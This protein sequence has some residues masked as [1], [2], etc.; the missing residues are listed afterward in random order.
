VGGVL[1]VV[2]AILGVI[3]FTAPAW[4]SGTA[5]SKFSDI[6]KILTA[7]ETK[8]Y[9]TTISRYYFGWLGWVLLAAAVATAILAVLPGIGSVFRIIAPIVAVAGLV[10]TFI[11]IKFFNDKAATVSSQ[12]S[13]YSTYLKHARLGFWLTVGAFV[14]LAIGGALGPRRTAPRAY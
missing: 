8:T 14:L 13:S 2:G 5:N 3:A 6:H 10:I 12:F 1:A 7:P 4:F 11:A 9:A